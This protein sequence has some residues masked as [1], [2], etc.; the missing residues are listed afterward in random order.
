MLL[1]NR[2]EV[3]EV[4]RRDGMIAIYRG[5]NKQTSKPVAIGLLRDIYNRDPKFVMR[6]QREAKVKSS[7]QHPNVVEVYD[8]G[9]S[10]GNY[11]VVMEWVDGKDLRHFL[12]P[13]GALEVEKA[14]LIARDVATGLGYMHDKGIVHRCLDPNKVLIGRGGMVKLVGFGIGWMQYY[15]PE[16]TQGETQ[17]PATDM[18]LLG[19]ILYEMLTS[20]PVFAGDTPVEIAMK[21]I[22]DQ[23]LP[24][25]RLGANIPIDLEEIVMKCLAKLPEDRFQNG[26]ELARALKSLYPL[27]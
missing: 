19:N 25:S 14:V 7:L 2:Y 3:R 10:S 12:H 6:F 22:Q 9:Q 24:P 1:S 26:N 16:Q 23:P 17:T 20:R 11:F 8:Y 5:V 15:A 21:H 13:R 4:M 18:Y 27:N